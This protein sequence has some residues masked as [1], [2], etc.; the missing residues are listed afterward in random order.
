MPEKET[1][2]IILRTYPLGEGD[3]LVSFL[4]RTAGRMR[5]VAAGARRPKSRFGSTLEV[6]SHVRL[7]YF[8]RETRDLVRIHQCDLLE[9]FL[10]AQQEYHLSLGLALI[11]EAA[12]MVLPERE[13]AD[14]VFRL[15]LASAR[16]IMTRNSIEVPLAYFAFWMV[17]LGGWLPPLDRCSRCGRLWGEGHAFHAPFLS[18]FVCG[19]CRQPGS[20]SLDA[21]GRRCALEMKAGRLETLQIAESRKTGLAQLTRAMLDLIEH[22]SE[23]KLNTRK[24][25]ESAA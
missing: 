6:L 10:G 3:R 2:A 11:S 9:S 23:K 14:A 22:H 7:W 17:R 16:A 12:E 5:G 19:D 24:L 20:Q 8:E 4:S 15:I 25:L 18:G 1:E 13:A 21:E